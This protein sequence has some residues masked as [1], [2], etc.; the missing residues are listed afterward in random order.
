M[1]TAARNMNPDPSTRSSAST[2]RWWPWQVCAFL[3]LAVALSYLD[4]QALS[5]VA[6]IIRRQDE[7]D[8]DNAQLG[9]LLSAFFWSFALMHLVTGWLFDR[10]NTRV[11]YALF[12]ALWSLSQVFSGLTWDFTSLFMA[13]VLLGAFETAGQTGAARIISRILPAR[14]RAL[15]NGIMMSGGA[16]GAIVAG[17]VMIGLANHVGW[18]AGFVILGALGLVWSAAWML[19]FRPPTAVVEGSVRGDHAVATRAQWETILARPSFWA[20]IGGAALTIPIIHI[21][22]AWIPTYFVDVWGLELDQG[23]ALYL[24]LIYLGLDVGFLGGGALVSYL[25][26]RGFSV[27]RARKIVMF[28]SGGL[29][30]SAAVVPFAQSVPW[31]VLLV[32]LLN[33][34]RAAWGAIFLAFNQDIAPARVGMI[35]AIMGCIGALAGAVLI[36][37]IGMTSRSHGYDIPFFLIASLAILGLIPILLVNWDEEQPRSPLTLGAVAE[38]S[39]KG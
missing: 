34:G 35:V 20:C 13:R 5:V 9:L 39:L 7:L 17:P 3:L 33:A 2:S 18:R 30:L 15:A 25:I 38:A 14:D 6:P 12:V 16:V 19:W 29:M 32:F 28:A 8:L 24:F 21:S 26:H 37:V 31:A 23:F 36:W 27:V 1:M 10:F 11:I 22:G 4:R